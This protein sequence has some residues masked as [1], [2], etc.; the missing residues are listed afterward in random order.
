MTMN[1]VT[2]S[3]TTRESEPHPQVSPPDWTLET[4][5]A[6]VPEPNFSDENV[7]VAMSDAP[8]RDKN[9]GPVSP[10][11]WTL[12]ALLANV[13]EPEPGAPKS[14]FSREVDTGPPVGKEV[15]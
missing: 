12:E 8:R 2:A 13:P 6:N 5:L 4:L 14:G 3:V 9:R 11:D 10:P 1:P 7:E 15:W